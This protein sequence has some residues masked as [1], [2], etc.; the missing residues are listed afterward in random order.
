MKIACS[1]VACSNVTFLLC[2]FGP[3]E[4]R[5]KRL[6]SLSERGLGGAY[7]DNDNDNNCVWA[8]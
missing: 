1:I 4:K 3:L 7:D 5:R 6:T 8:G 2:R